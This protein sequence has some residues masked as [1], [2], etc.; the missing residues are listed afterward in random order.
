MFLNRRKTKAIVVGTV[1]ILVSVAMFLYWSNKKEVWFCDE[2]YTFESAHGMEQDWPASTTGQWM[3]GEEMEAFFSA[4]SD[5]LSLSY[6]SNTLYNDHV[7]LYFWLYRII[8][9]FCF[10]GSATIWTGYTI[11]LIFYILFLLTGYVFFTQITKKPMVAGC[12]MLCSGVVN[13]I[14]IAQ[15]TTL[16]M[17]MMLVFWELMLVILALLIL[18]D[19]DKKK[20]NITTHITLCVFSTLGLLTH[21]DYWVFYAITAAVFCIWLLILALKEK[22]RFWNTYQFRHVCAWCVNFVVSLLLTI[23]IFPY[24]RW[25][26]NRGKG[27][28]ALHSLFV[29]SRKK[30]DNIS[31]GI[32]CLSASIF[33]ESIPAVVG[34][35]LIL[36]CVGCGAFLLYKEKE[37]KK[38]AGLILIMLVSLGYQLTICFTMPDVNE[39][40]YLWGSFT[41]VHMCFL[42]SG[43]LLLKA[44]CRKW[45]KENV[46]KG[47]YAVGCLL[48][49]L[50]Q[51]IVIDNGNGVT[52]LFHPEKDIEVLE[53][54]SDVPW[55]VYG[56]TIGVYSY[57]DWLI[58]QEICF[59]SPDNT[60]EDVAAVS[61]LQEKGSF[62]LYTHQDYLPQAISFFEEELGKDLSSTF[63]TKSTNLTVY[64]IEE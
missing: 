56:P 12:I 41:L 16:R 11:N 61:A 37:F 31:W 22:K 33:G 47:L 15:A 60:A 48:W 40:R 54:H 6:I 19:S 45:K 24:C 4:D 53:T 57:Y 55:V 30:L 39:E 28:T 2:I 52:Y 51:V 62:V 32:E 29:F 36:C 49:L 13:K 8:A 3:T 42:W 64:L 10:K 25:N 58:P 44:L 18:K 21:Y 59:L 63:L 1:L 26:L 35:I 5:S 27:Q 20:L 9:F 7:P 14:M 17:Y 46:R 34:M 50:V 43:Y 23:A 38:T